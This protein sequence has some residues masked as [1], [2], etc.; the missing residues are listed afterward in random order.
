MVENLAKIEKMPSGLKINKSTKNGFEYDQLAGVSDYD[1][2]DQ[3]I[4]AVQDIIDTDDET[5][6]NEPGESTDV[7]DPNEIKSINKRRPYFDTNGNEGVIETTM[8]H[9]Q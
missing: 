1:L 4:A 8:N 9:S 5:K 6:E 7:I 3:K 2:E